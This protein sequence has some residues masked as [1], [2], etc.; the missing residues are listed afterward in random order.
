MVQQSSKPLFL[1]FPRRSAHAAQSLGH[2][3]PALC[4]LS[5]GLLDV[6]L[7]LPPSLHCL[8]RRFPLFVRLFHRYYSAVRLLPS[9][10]VR[11]AALRLHRPVY[12]F[13]RRTGGLP[14][15]VHVVSRRAR[16]FDHAVSR[17]DSRFYA[18]A[19]VAFPLS[20]QGR[21]TVRQFSGLNRPAHRCLYLRF[22][23]RLAAH[24]ARLKVG[25]ESLLLS[26]RALS[27]P[28]NMPVYPG[29]LARQH[30]PS[31]LH[32]HHQLKTIAASNGITYH[33]TV[34]S[35]LTVCLTHRD[36]PKPTPRSLGVWVVH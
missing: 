32:R 9:V 22:A 2:S 33:R 23:A 16:V 29:A 34:P 14:V 5:A 25:I 1:P 4:R 6:L 12:L 31:P 17:S 13:G 27:S 11:I 36:N 15:L 3:F 10:R 24:H 21:H 26:R 19:D 30:C 18:H 8:R 7:G 20:K 35:L 28:T